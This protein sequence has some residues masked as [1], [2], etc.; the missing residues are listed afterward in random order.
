MLKVVVPSFA[1]VLASV[2]VLSAAEKSSEI[3]S[4]LE[5]G[6]FAPAF[7][8][9]DITGPKKGT[10][11]CYRCRYGSRPVV[12]IFAREITPELTELIKNVDKQVDANKDKRMA[13]FV[14]F[15]SEDGEAA[16]PKIKELADKNKIKIPLTLI[17]NTKGP[18]NYNISEDADVTVMMWVDSEVKV[19]HAFG[20][21]KLKKETVKEIAADTKKI[22][23]D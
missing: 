7:D 15:L 14:V 3:Q 23:A 21:G 11:L 17:K 19:N 12:N 4:G 6:S 13:A 16:E 8:V 1:L 18:D 9:L 2:V 5:L 10:E 20:K 22:L